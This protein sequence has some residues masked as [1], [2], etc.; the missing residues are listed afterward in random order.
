MYECKTPCRSAV[1]RLLAQAHRSRCVAFSPKTMSVP[2]KRPAALLKRPAA[3]EPSSRPKAKRSSAT[4]VACVC[5]AWSDSGAAT[6]ASL[7]EEIAKSTGADY[8]DK[9]T[10]ASLSADVS[11]VLGV[12]FPN[13][14]Y[15]AAVVGKK[16]KASPQLASRG[17]GAKHVY[18]VGEP[19]CLRHGC[20]CSLSD[21]AP[22]DVLVADRVEDMHQLVAA[23]K[24]PA[25][26][27]S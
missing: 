4:A 10:V 6:L 1:A 17:V 15:V 13:L 25:C 27:I 3:A 7:R 19:M 23:L 16:G 2:L 26:A 18:V 11:S 14:S 21:S 20:R 12:D 24:I 8:R 5:S 9:I 22:I